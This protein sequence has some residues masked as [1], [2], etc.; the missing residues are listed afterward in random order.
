MNFTPRNRLQNFDQSSQNFG[1]L[2]QLQ[3]QSYAQPVSWNGSN[4]GPSYTR[5][6]N[7]SCIGQNCFL[8]S[9]VQPAF[10]QHRRIPSLLSIPT[11]QHPHSGYN[12]SMYRRNNLQYRSSNQ[13]QN[14][15]TEYS[16]CNY[17]NIT[18]S[19]RGKKKTNR[20]EAKMA[21]MQNVASTALKKEVKVDFQQTLDTG[22]ANKSNFVDTPKKKVSEEKKEGNKMHVFYKMF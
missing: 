12:D 9:N 14:L 13:R 3:S 1:H 4:H 18:D 11:W 21:P 22:S 20:Q 2:N 10:V 16:R 17:G 19:S 8:N 6:G 5:A 15:G 7:D